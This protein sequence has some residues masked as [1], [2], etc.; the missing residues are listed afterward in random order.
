M[1]YIHIPYCHRKCNYCAFYSAVTS[2]DTQPYVDALC[3]EIR[4][5]KPAEKHTVKTVYFGGGTPSLLPI[6]QLRQIVECISQS[7]FDVSQVEEVTLE[8]NPEDI[9]MAYM[10]SLRQLR[11]I[12][13]ISIG[14]QSFKDSNLRIMN[15]RHEASQSV[16]ALE[17]VRQ[18]GFDNVSVDLIYGLPHQ[19]LDDWL[20]ELDILAGL[21]EHNEAIQHLSAYALTVEPHTILDYQIS[22]KM[23]RPASEDVVLL[24]YEALHRWCS[25]SGFAQ[26]E[27]SNYCRN[28]RRSI[29]N[30]NYWNRTPYW[31]FGTSAHSF[32][33]VGR[34]WNVSDIKQYIA[35][36]R[37]GE[38]YYE[39]ETLSTRDVHN[40]YLMTALRTSAGISKSLIDSRY[41]GSLSKGIRKYVEGGLIIETATHYEPTWQALLQADGIAS[42]LFEITS[43][44]EHNVCD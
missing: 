33:G 18:A 4:Q 41:A 20:G 11:F 44:G 28:G 37:S 40:E 25:Q 34:R 1:I 21:C 24:Q 5:R 9:S 38:A 10:E 2:G 3:E 22:H 7:N 39:S 35:G 29:H 31:G 26:Y 27:I 8:C 23:L 6:A 16:R 12:N 14:L 13:R 43:K 15:R 32:D 30:S 36:V 42:E 19:T 17:C